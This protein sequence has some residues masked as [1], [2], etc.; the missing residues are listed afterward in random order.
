MA[1]A[2]ELEL[3]PSVHEPFAVHPLSATDLVEHVDGPLLENACSR[4]AL[5]VL[6]G[7]QLED[8]RVHSCAVE[9]LSEHQS[10]GARADDSDLGAFRPQP[11][12]SSLRTSWKIANAELAA[13]T[14]Q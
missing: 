14:P 8:D 10:G 13:G 3:D 7:T 12:A 4:S 1:L 11:P 2:G 5:D 6:A 9:K